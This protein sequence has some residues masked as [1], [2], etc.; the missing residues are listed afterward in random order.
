MKLPPIQKRR[1]MSVLEVTLAL[2]LLGV[3]VAMAAQV[4]AICARQRLAGEQVLVAQWEADNVLE[5]LAGLRYQEVTADS[6]KTIQPSPQLM[7]PCLR[8]SCTSRSPV[9][10]ATIR[11]TPRRRT[12]EFMSK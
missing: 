5:H 6:V 7:R 1:G 3:G 2:A 11:P 4:F 12:N 9:P 8:P 10:R